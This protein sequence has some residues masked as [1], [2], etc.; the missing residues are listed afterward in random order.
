MALRNVAGTLGS[1][2]GTG[3][4]A[5]GARGLGFLGMTN[6]IG[7]ALNLGLAGSALYKYLK[8]QNKI[9]SNEDRWK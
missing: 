2:V 5:L 1:K 9:K 4:L 7:I 6:P 8:Q 3:A